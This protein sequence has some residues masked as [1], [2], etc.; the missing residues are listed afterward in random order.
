[1]ELALYGPGGYYQQTRPIGKAGDYFTNV[2]VG[3]LF[4]QL[5]A[6][7]FAQWFAQWP[8]QPLEVIEAGAHDG[9]LALDLLGYFHQFCPGAAARLHYSFF[10][11]IPALRSR[12]RNRTK[13]FKGKVRWLRSWPPPPSPGPRIIF[14]NEFLDAMPVRRLG[15]DSTAR[16]WFEW[17][18]TLKN[19][20]LLWAKLP[21]PGQNSDVAGP[22]TPGRCFQ[23]NSV[24]L[25][26]PAW[27]EILPDN[28]TVEVSPG[29]Q[30]WW[31]NAALH[32]TQG[33]LVTID[34][35]FVNEEVP[36]PWLGQGTL[37][38][39]Q[40]HRLITDILQSPGELD[41]TAHVDFSQV[42]QTGLAAGLTTTV[43]GFQRQWLTHLA[44]AT[45]AQPQLFPAWTPALIR[46]FHTLTHPEHLGD[47][48]RV[49]VQRAAAPGLG[50][51]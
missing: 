49:L 16:A 33:Y 26:P 38:G 4:G 25:P 39:Y 19:R 14:S 18:V 29:A 50:K 47:K 22:P 1:M 12:Q 15:W 3:P 21:L 20:S 42:E 2:S 24:S 9:T 10:E 43:H 5:L 34:Y 30:N 7:Q 51:G 35:G 27:Q 46:Q 40:N 44:A 48:F 28:F 36:A 31:R 37:R 23:G 45:W 17:G 11:P 32:L 13:A 6:F 8:D 41:L